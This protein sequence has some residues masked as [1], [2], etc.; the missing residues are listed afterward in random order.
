MTYDQS[1]TTYVDWHGD[2]YDTEMLACGYKA[3]EWAVDYFLDLNLDPSV[4]ILDVCSGTGLVAKFL[5]EKSPADRNYT[6][7][8][9]LDSSK[10]MLQGAKNLGIYKKFYCC[11]IGGSC[12]PAPI[13]DGK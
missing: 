11:P 12:P 6:N 1:Q 3:P 10:E 4:R 13:A 8:D 5:N 2:A 9:A 7:I